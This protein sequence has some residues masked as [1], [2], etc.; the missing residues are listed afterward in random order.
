MREKLS[1]ITPL[2]HFTVSRPIRHTLPPELESDLFGSRVNGDCST[3]SGTNNEICDS[4]SVLNDGILPALSG[5]SNDSTSQWANELFTM[6]RSG[7]NEVVVSLQVPALNYNFVELTLFNCPRMGIHVPKASLYVGNALSLDSVN[8]N[9]VANK[10]LTE[11]SC[12]HLL[13]FCM[14]FGGAV[15]APIFNLV[16]PYFKDIESN[17]TFVFLGE[18]TFLN[19]LD[20]PLC[21]SPEQITM[22]V[23]P[24]G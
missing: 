14:Q 8:L 21:P 11:T 12:D 7:T 2:F 3:T 23:P 6:R 5:V 16:F 18:V 20:N 10:T 13:K 24:I 17:S 15:G 4:T 22:R 1:C 19:V 9:M